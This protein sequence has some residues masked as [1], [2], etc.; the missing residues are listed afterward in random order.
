M[1]ATF[2]PSSGAGPSE[3][4]AGGDG[5]Q[6]GCPF[7]VGD[8]VFDDVF[9]TQAT[10]TELP[11]ADEP[12]LDRRGKVCIRFDEDDSEELV[13][14]SWDHLKMVKRARR[15]PAVIDR[16]KAL[17]PPRPAGG[18][19]GFG[20]TRAE[21]AQ[22][23]AGATAVAQRRAAA[24]AAAAAATA[25][26]ASASVAAAA[27]AQPSLSRAAVETDDEYPEMSNLSRSRAEKKK[28]PA[29]TR[30]RQV[31]PAKT[32]DSHVSIDERQKQFPNHYLLKDFLT[33]GLFCGACRKPLQNIKSSIN[34]HIQTNGHVQAVNAKLRRNGD[35]QKTKDVIEEYYTADADR[36]GTSVDEECRLYRYRVME[37]SMAAGVAPNQL[38][39]FRPVLE[40]YG[41]ALTD[42]SH[43]KM[44]VPLIL[45]EEKSRQLKELDGQYVSIAYDGTAREG[46]A[47]NVVTRHC[48][49]EFELVHRLVSFKTAAKHLDGKSSAALVT[50]L[51]IKDLQLPLDKLIAIMCDSA[52]ANGV[53]VRI[54]S[55][56]FI[57]CSDILC[58][59]H[60]LSHVGDHF[61]WKVLD[62]F[63][64]PWVTLVCNNK[65][66]RK[67]WNELIGEAA[68]GFSNVR[69]YCT[70][71]IAMQISKYFHL[72]G[73]FLEQLEFQGIGQTTTTK[74][75]D[76]Y[77]NKESCLQ[78]RL[79]CAAMMVRA[80][81]SCELQ[82]ARAARGVGTRADRVPARIPRSRSGL[83]PPCVRAGHAE[84]C[85]CCVQ[86]R[87]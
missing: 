21:P 33:G 78:L 8:V 18:L 11:R 82:A 20:F 13:W 17:P 84:P 58:I 85:G 53:A 74:M 7:A 54:M 65:G 68:Q 56:T 80:R 6:E 3:H 70:A 39:K 73:T 55:S 71:E 38:D 86:A 61:E 46:D 24:A 79:E 31:G 10:V 30:G 49:P 23:T 51:L 72:L 83:P 77:K 14:R 37:A 27:L 69:W 60:T 57:S 25:V 9:E 64:T 34:S 50:Q 26:S 41:P 28:P 5:A 47:V 15:A 44:Y 63:L 40:R 48:T 2:A 45:K 59:C 43:L 16:L 4:A 75:M 67:L 42:S 35:D 36:A 29:V 76:I 87:G 81:A 19:F 52:A 66:A 12:E 22:T 32:Q 62:A 1:D